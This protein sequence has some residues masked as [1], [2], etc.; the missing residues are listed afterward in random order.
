MLQAAWAVALVL[1]MLGA[2][3]LDADPRGYL[4]VFAATQVGVHALQVAILSARGLLRAGRIAAHELVGA[5][6]SILAFGVVF[7]ANA[8]AER[9][10]RC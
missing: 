2:W 7:V 8:R 5:A 4:Y 10:D 3:R 6:I 1:G 9:M